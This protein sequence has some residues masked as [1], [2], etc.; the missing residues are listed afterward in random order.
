LDL[1]R[2]G[3]ALDCR[4]GIRPAAPTY[5]HLAEKFTSVWSSTEFGDPVRRCVTVSAPVSPMG[6]I[7]TLC[8]DRTATVLPLVTGS[9]NALGM[10]F[11]G[12]LAGDISGQRNRYVAG[13][14]RDGSRSD[15]WTDV[16]RCAHAT[17]VR[18]VPACECGW[19]GQDHPATPAGYQACTRA[20]AQ[21]H[22][23]ATPASTTLER[24]AVTVV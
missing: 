17:F 6:L 15:I 20:W 18:Y 23:C 10:L 2:N 21:E 14:Y 9:L 22:H 24:S 11:V 8:G 16:T 7:W 1:P 5:E 19:H 13:R 12:G 3:L 4:V